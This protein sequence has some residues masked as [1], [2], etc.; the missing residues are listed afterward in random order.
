[1]STETPVVSSVA[2]SRA[3]RSGSKGSAT[4]QVRIR[5]HDRAS[6]AATASPIPAWEA[7]QRL[8][9]GQR[10]SVLGRAR[11]QAATT[12]FCTGS[13]APMRKMVY[14]APAVDRV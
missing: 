5:P 8:S 3:K 13:S 1:M 6:Q 10:R 2:Y 11:T 9:I 14:S 7:I 12:R 4:D